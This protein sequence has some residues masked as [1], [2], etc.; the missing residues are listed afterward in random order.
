MGL[1]TRP[2]SPRPRRLARQSTPPPPRPA[3]PDPRTPPD[4]ARFIDDVDDVERVV[5]IDEWDDDDDDVP[6]PGTDTIKSH[7]DNKAKRLLEGPDDKRRD[8]LEND[9]KN[10]LH[11][12]PEVTFETL[13]PVL[14]ECVPDW[15]MELQLETA[16]RLGDVVCLELSQELI[17]LITKAMFRVVESALGVDDAPASDLYGE[18]WTILQEVLPKI[19]WT[20]GDAAEVI[21]VVDVH[22]KQALPTSR[23]MAARILGA[24]AACWVEVWVEKEILPRVERLFVDA[25]VQ[26]RGVAIESMA[27]LGAALPCRVTEDRVWPQVAD[28]LDPEEDSRIFGTAMRTM[29]H[30]LRKQREKGASGRLFRDMLPPV[31][32]KLCSFARR[33]GVMDQR[34][35]EDSTYQTLEIVSEV[36]GEFLYSMSL[37]SRSRRSLQ[38]GFKAFS[39]MA[40]CNGPL[41]RRACVYNAPGVI[42]ALGDRFAM[43]LSG[44]C[45][46]LAQDT[47]EDVRWNLA[48]GIHECAG[49]LYESLGGS[50]D[51]L[52]TAVRSL[53]EDENPEVRMKAFEHFYELMS[54]FI[55]D[56]A[57]P[58]SLLRL[59]PVFSNLTVLSETDWRVQKGLAE[60]LGKC[61]DIMLP[62]ALIDYVLPL[63][64]QLIEKGTPP[65]RVAA[66]SAIVRAVRCIPTER[67]RE[68]CLSTFWMQTS[69]GPFW[70]RLTLLDG[71]AAA[72][73]TFSAARFSTMFAPTIL[74]I[75]ADPVANVRIRF[76]TLL[77]ELA[78][79]CGQ[80]PAYAKAVELMQ[81]DNDPD[82]VL[83]MQ[84][85]ER[86][87]ES[88]LARAQASAAVDS[89]RFREE[90]ELWGFIP[91][92]V[93]R[94]RGRLGNIRTSRKLSNNSR[95]RDSSDSMVDQFRRRDSCSNMS[96]QSSGQLSVSA[97]VVSAV[98]APPSPTAAPM[99]AE[100]AAVFKRQPQFS[101]GHQEELVKQQDSEQQR[102][103]S[104]QHQMRQNSSVRRKKQ[105][106]PA[107]QQPSPTQEQ[108][109][110]QQQSLTVQQQQQLA[111]QKQQLM[112]KQL[113][114]MQEQQQAM[115]RQKK[116]STGLA[117]SAEE[118][119]RSASPVTRSESPVA[120]LPSSAVSHS[121]MAAPALPGLTRASAEAATALNVGEIVGVDSTPIPFESS[122]SSLSAVQTPV[123]P[124]VA[125]LLPERAGNERPPSPAGQVRSISPFRPASPADSD[126]AMSTSFLSTSSLANDH[127]EAE[128]GSG[129]TPPGI[130]DVANSAGSEPRLR[131][132]E[133][134]AP[135]PLLVSGKDAISKSAPHSHTRR[136]PRSS[137]AAPTP[138]SEPENG[139]NAKDCLTSSTSVFDPVSQHE[140]SSMSK[141]GF[142]S[143]AAMTR[144]NADADMDSKSMA[145]L[146]F[147]PVGSEQS[148]FGGNSGGHDAPSAS[149]PAR[150]LGGQSG[151]FV[152]RGTPHGDSVSMF[153]LGF[154][155][156]STTGTNADVY[157]D[158]KSMANLKF[159][160]VGGQSGADVLTG[161]APLH[162][163][164]DTADL[165]RRTS[166]W[167]KRFAK[168]PRQVSDVLL[169][170]SSNAVGTASDG[171][172]ST[173]LKE[174]MGNVL[175]W[176]RKSERVSRAAISEAVRQLEASVVAQNPESISATGGPRSLSFADDHSA[177]AKRN[178]SFGSAI[179]SSS[180]TAARTMSASAGDDL[181]EKRKM[182]LDLG[183]SSTEDSYDV[184]SMKFGSEARLPSFRGAAPW[185]RK[186]GAEQVRHPGGKK[187]PLSS[188]ERSSEQMG[189]SSQSGLLGQMN[190]R[191]QEKVDQMSLIDS[192]ADAPLAQGIRAD[193]D[194]SNF[195]QHPEKR[196]GRAQSDFNF[197]NNS[198]DRSHS[199]FGAATAK[200]TQTSTP[201]TSH[202]PEKGTRKSSASRFLQT[203][204]RR[205][206]RY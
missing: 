168:L 146:K 86:N 37:H 134:V 25:D 191:S 55:R 96:D 169:P 83:V 62:E 45:K 167:T 130:S 18:C 166:L 34:H 121:R 197:V 97:D 59:A 128:A 175:H 76:A 108:Q 132:A 26:V 31:F 154:K 177:A 126:V 16:F 22:A 106:P 125:P 49:L 33:F 201:H 46:F 19:T 4:D 178:S 137:T 133:Q 104:S 99:P 117:R 131:S 89:A 170:G 150:T 78:P 68:H 204:F 15:G 56:Y 72:L 159:V 73:K 94:S 20:A 54:V 82:V 9:L 80:T 47:D 101:T 42:K 182:A 61:T 205:K 13:L 144:G 111:V 67:E 65:V 183:F 143:S 35:V 38:A 162:P 147:K 198:H 135:V 122:D 176:K 115:Q 5:G 75:A 124:L 1:R 57:D 171:E 203:M 7:I 40:T 77:P 180:G 190:Q 95:R 186:A 141:L 188:F 163:Q 196:T 127:E 156:S 193:T 74:T 32:H 28:L 29:S 21:R 52:L 107:V 23:K 165:V 140:S 119:A 129:S 192:M 151:S 187:I 112:E 184:A 105:G 160:P 27:F 161:S 48:A 109:V 88:S 136:G 103:L 199:Y 200:R 174:K 172:G 17:Q 69:T 58:S 149:G 66:M 195:M 24:L 8:V 63:L 164:S 44:F 153:Q 100:Q 93:K 91:R 70:M 12:A 3:T 110:A 145:N 39:S 202:T 155:S 152:V 98:N 158:A 79:S 71:G 53:L 194:L 81:N 148:A 116:V 36:F 142:K 181:E 120:Q 139:Q 10:L 50:H 102:K 87:S 123:A 64:Y 179:D 118:P 173:S 60:Q 30:I 90:Q 11:H 84:N 185:M 114:K 14:C 189:H 2:S 113:V 41:I 157:T 6:N 206:K 51:S 92:S 43:E 138:S 85:F